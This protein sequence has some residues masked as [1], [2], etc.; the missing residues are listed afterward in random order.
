MEGTTSQFICT[1]TRQTR[2]AIQ[3]LLKERIS[4]SLSRGRL[5]VVCHRSRPAASERAP[6]PSER[7]TR[8]CERQQT[9]PTCACLSEPRSPLTP[10]SHS[11]QHATPKLNGRLES[12]HLHDTG[13]HVP[14][15]PLPDV[16]TEGDVTG[17]TS[18]GSVKYA[19]MAVA[20]TILCDQSIAPCPYDTRLRISSGPMRSL[21]SMIII[22]K[23]AA[24]QR[25]LMLYRSR[26]FGLLP[27]DGVLQLLR[28]R[29]L[30][31]FTC[32]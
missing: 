17:E 19:S 16:G 1:K 32:I 30:N 26:S 14:M 7:T 8:A 2:D 29:P 6:P 9:S 21:C 11:Y 13:E 12:G 15:K 23:D 5:L 4:D 3:N 22:V 10:Q 24:L 18:A 31:L 27:G 20:C 28:K 25:H